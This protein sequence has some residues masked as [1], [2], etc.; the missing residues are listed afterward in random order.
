[1]VLSSECRQTL[2][3][4]FQESDTKLL[5]LCWI[6]SISTRKRFVTWHVS[7]A[8]LG[9]AG[10]RGGEIEK[11]QDFNTSFFFFGGTVK[12]MEREEEDEEEALPLDM[13]DEDDLQLMRELGQ[14]A[15]FL[16]RDLSS[17]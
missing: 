10:G 12:R 16:T 15:S 5:A 14:K 17:R 9:S 4:R 3:F 6:K 7:S 11:M 1:M 8:F 13:M 2:I